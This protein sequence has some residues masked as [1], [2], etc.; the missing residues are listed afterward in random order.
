VENE[1]YAKLWIQN[2][3]S[4]KDFYHEDY[5]HP[6]LKKF[7]TNAKIL[8]AGCGIGIITNYLKPNQIYFGFDQIEE[9]I[10]YAKRKNN[11]QNIKFKIE[12]LPKI[13]FPEKFDIIICSMVIH[14]LE[15][16]EDT[17][18]NL[19]K[20]LKKDGT[21]LLIHFNN[22]SEILLRNTVSNVK[23]SDE[24]SIEGN[25]ELGSGIKIPTKIIFHKEKEIEKAIEKQSFEK[26]HF[27]KIFV[28]YKIKNN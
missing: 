12:S 14:H 8:D 3:E 23:F 7:I 1:K 10:N 4:K 16:I 28:A 22:E 2:I 19:S 5:L 18:N 15:E 20:K 27:G 6:F 26:E 25:V 21:L 13:P 11:A 9:F 17:I 24:K